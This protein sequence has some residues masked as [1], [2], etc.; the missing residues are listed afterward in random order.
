MVICILK[1]M[2]Q[3]V[4][5]RS[6]DWERVRALEAVMLERKDLVNLGAEENG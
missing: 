6:R 5:W 2:G 1:Y 3:M 4:A